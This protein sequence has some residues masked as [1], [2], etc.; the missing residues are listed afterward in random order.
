MFESLFMAFESFYTPSAN[1]CPRAFLPSS[2][3]IESRHA[4][5]GRL[6]WAEV[7]EASERPWR[8]V[9]FSSRIGQHQT[10]DRRDFVWFE[11]SWR[12][13]YRQ[14]QRSTRA[15]CSGRSLDT[16]QLT[17][18]PHPILHV[19]SSSTMESQK[20]E[21]CVRPEIRFVRGKWSV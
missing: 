17:L 6:I 18:A 15:T 21:L 2:T 3:H 20:V 16:H 12:K 8:A 1:K 19:V 9:D 7:G 11:M 10:T 14:F 13:A 5:I 4:E